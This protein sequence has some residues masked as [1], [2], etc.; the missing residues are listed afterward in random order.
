M[1]FLT[2]LFRKQSVSDVVG[3]IEVMRDKLVELADE[4]R[5]EYENYDALATTAYRESMRAGNV[6]RKLDELVS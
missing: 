3:Q 5:A 6:S 2:S 4:K 1:K